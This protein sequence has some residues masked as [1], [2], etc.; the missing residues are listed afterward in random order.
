MVE[1]VLAIEDELSSEE[2]AKLL[3]RCAGL[4]VA[5]WSAVCAHGSARA[6][7]RPAHLCAPS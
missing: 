3:S 2:A 4:L 1:R 7:D 6:T 5:I